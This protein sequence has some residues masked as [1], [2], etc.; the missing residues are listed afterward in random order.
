MGT[1]LSGIDEMEAALAPAERTERPSLTYLSLTAKGGYAGGRVKVQPLQE[2][3][4][5]SPAYD[6]DK[7]LGFITWYHQSPYNWKRSALC[8]MKDGACFACEQNGVDKD[9]NGENQPWYARK[10]FYINL[11]VTPEDKHP[12][13]PDGEPY[14]A[15]FHCPTTGNGILPDL[16]NWYKDNGPITEAVFTMSRSGEQGS[17]AHKLTP[18]LKDEPV[19]ISQYVTQDAR[20]GG[21]PDVPYDR[22]AKFYEFVT[23]AQKAVVEDE[24]RTASTIQW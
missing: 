18:R 8:T 1:F 2:I 15:V 24:A 6:E 12:D 17:T 13:S 11:L 9:E 4:P 14:V 10:R 23:P 5:N 7:G 19:D 22:Q 20:A 16:M 21:Y 3:D